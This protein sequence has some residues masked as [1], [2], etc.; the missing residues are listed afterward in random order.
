MVWQPLLKGLKLH[1]ER[2]LILLAEQESLK[3]LKEQAQAAEHST[4]PLH[5]SSLQRISQR[6]TSQ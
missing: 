3:Q 1:P 6:P 2:H 5:E 4:C